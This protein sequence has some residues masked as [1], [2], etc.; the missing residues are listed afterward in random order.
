MI[1][2][3]LGYSINPYFNQHIDLEIYQLIFQKI[4]LPV[5]NIRNTLIKSG[6][7]HL[8]GL[9]SYKITNKNGDIKLPPEVTEKIDAAL[10]D[11][12]TLNVL[13]IDPN[14]HFKNIEDVTYITEL[15]K[16]RNN[17]KQ[18]KDNSFRR[19]VFL[20]QN[21]ST[22][23][24]KHISEISYKHQLPIDFFLKKGGSKK[25]FDNL[26]ENIPTGL[27]YVY[28]QLYRDMQFDR[29]IQKNDLEDIFGLTLALPLC[30]VI[31]TEKMWLSIIKRAKLDRTC[32]VDVIHSITQFYS[33]L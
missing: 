22:T 10:N 24:M 15:E 28:L 4:G 26:L 3:S 7:P 27:V 23:I 30:D 19:R 9:G 13:L 33:Y 32:R 18:F 17:L 20:A 25:D 29:A 1:K 5:S 8:L 12:N 6:I 14:P 2:L 16:I 31:L 21:I 11:P